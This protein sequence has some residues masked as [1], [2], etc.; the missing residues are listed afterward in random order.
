MLSCH[1]HA[2][3]V[4]HF[5]EA[6]RLARECEDPFGEA[7]AWRWLAEAHAWQ[8]HWDEAKAAITQARALY[9]K[10]GMAREVAQCDEM[11]GAKHG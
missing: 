7:P 4:R 9:L 11:L 8:Q 10:M 5:T 1:K 2:E 3:A 6:I